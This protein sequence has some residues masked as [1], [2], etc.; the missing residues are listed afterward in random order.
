LHGPFLVL[1]RSPTQCAWCIFGSRLEG[2]R[3]RLDGIT[4]DL[5]C[6]FALSEIVHIPLVVRTT[7][8]K[9]CTFSLA[10]HMGPLCDAR[11]LQK[12]KNF[13]T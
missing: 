9:R 3:Y 10:V 6:A 13:T 1:W 8:A 2:L 12:R 5:D 7:F 4:R 11:G